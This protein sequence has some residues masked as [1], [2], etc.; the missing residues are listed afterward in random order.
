MTT[1]KAEGMAGTSETKTKIKENFKKRNK[2]S[3]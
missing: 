2:H 3:K 1:G